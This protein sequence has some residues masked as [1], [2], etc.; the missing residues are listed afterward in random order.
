[1]T[2][3]KAPAGWYPHPSMADTRRYWDGERWT[4]HI[5]PAEPA[6]PKATSG[7]AANNYKGMV[8]GGTAMAFLMPLIGFII[9]AYLLS[10]RPGPGI[11]I[12]II[13]V[14]AGLFWYS[15]LTTDSTGY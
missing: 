3:K 13:S 1:M 14:L 8:A 4:S 15:Q 10:K 9:G 12:M 6:A 7:P 11:A 2:G 5:A